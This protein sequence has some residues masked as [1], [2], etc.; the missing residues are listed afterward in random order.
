MKQ[1]VFLTIAL[2]CAIAQG[3][4]AGEILTYI[5]RTW[6]GDKKELKVQTGSTSDYVELTSSDDWV[7]MNAATSEWYVVKGNVSIKVLKVTG[8][9]KLLLCDDARLETTHVKLE[10]GQIRLIDGDELH[11]YAQQDGSG[12]LISTSTETGWAGIGGGSVGHGGML[13][14]HGGYVEARAGKYAAGI[15]GGDNGY[16]GEYFQYGGEVKAYGGDYGAGI[17]TGDEPPFAYPCDIKIHG[18]TVWASGGDGSGSEGSFW[19]MTDG[20]AGIGSGYAGDGCNICIDGGT[21]YAEGG[22]NAPG[23]GISRIHS[24]GYLNISGGNIT[25]KAGRDWQSSI[26]S[27]R[28]TIANLMRV[29][30][31]S[32]ANNLTPAPSLGA[33]KR[34]TV[35]HSLPYGPAQTTKCSLT[36]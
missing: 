22:K 32:D 12:Q 10:R 2:L 14:V 20:G 1:K 3:G 30:A 13:H 15:G 7:E 25:A 16:A 6:D 35:S 29:D 34:W 28:P 23:I 19:G 17:G 31:G 5:D 21:I 27:Y 26:R 36:S 8:N 9:V 33:T 4:W 18:G 24:Y 11:I